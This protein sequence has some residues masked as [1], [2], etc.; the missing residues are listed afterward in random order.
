MFEFESGRN[1]RKTST[2]KRASGD[3]R[4]ERTTEERAEDAMS[5]ELVVGP[6]LSGKSNEVA[7]RMRRQAVAGR[8]CLVVRHEADCERF[9][10]CPRDQIV[11]HDRGSTIGAVVCACL[12]DVVDL[13]ARAEVVGVDEGQ[14]FPDLAEICEYWANMGK[15]VFVAALDANYDRKPF[16]N[17]TDLIPIAEKVKKIRGVCSACG[18]EAAFSKLAQSR[19]GKTLQE[20]KR[21]LMRPV[22]RGCYFRKTVSP[23]IVRAE[24]P[25]IESLTLAFDSWSAPPSPRTPT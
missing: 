18:E 25:S 7:D 12:R 13:V 19:D 5:I 17:V 10:E 8:R 20:D 1:R 21:K 6:A 3:L 15:K 11:T 2:C 14:L 9:C 16:Q 24:I 22:C 23:K 4:V